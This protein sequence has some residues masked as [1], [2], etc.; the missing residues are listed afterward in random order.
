MIESREQRR[1]STLLHR[2]KV[3]IIASVLIVAILSVSLY[4]IY[5]YFNSVL[6]FRDANYGDEESKEQSEYYIVKIDGEFKMYYDKKG[7]KLLPTDIPMGTDD[8]LFVTDIGTT[9]EVNPETGEVDVRSIPAI[10]YD[11]GE[12]AE[13]IDHDYLTIFKGIDAKNIR[14]I[15]VHNALGDYTIC[16]LNSETLLPDDTSDFVLMNAPLVSVNQ[17][18]LSYL[19]YYAAHPLVYKRL[20]DPI[21]DSDGKYSEY[22]LAPETRTDA[23]G[24]EYKYTPSYYVITTTSDVE[25][26]IIIGDAL[27]DGSGY[28][29]Q[30]QDNDGKLRDS[31]YI[32]KPTDMTEV[33]GTTFEN[34]ILGPAKNYI[35]PYIVYPMSMND[36]YDVTDFS[37]KHRV[38][39]E[40]QEIVNFSF[41][42]LEDRTGTVHGIHPYVF[43]D[44]SFH[45]YHPHYDNIDLA[46]QGLMEPDISDIAIINPTDEQKAEYGLMKAVTGEDGKVSYVYDSK[47]TVSFRRTVKNEETGESFDLVQTVYISEKSEEGCY[48]TF[49]EMR[50]P[51][52]TEDSLFKGIKI[53]MI[54]EVSESSL[55]FV[56]WDTNDWVYPAFMQIG[57]DYLDNVDF[58]W[59]D[60]SANFKTENGEVNGT[61]VF[62]VTLTDSDKYSKDPLK[63]FGVLNFK[64]VGG[65][66][67]V[68]TPEQILVYSAADG[69]KLKPQTRH[70]EYNSIGDQVQV[71]DPDKFA[72]TAAGDKV[73][74]N[75]D[76]ITIL[77][78]NGSSETIMR[79]QTKLF[80]KMF[81]GIN[82]MKIVDAYHLT[83]EEEAALIADTDKHLLTIRTTD[84]EGTVKTYSFYSVTDRKAYITVDG[85]GG[86]Y[87]QTKSINKIANDLDKFFKGE[88]IDMDAI[89]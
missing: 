15:E 86:F 79:Y 67:W 77:H 61:A 8:E 47:Y 28:Y 49:T 66:T 17:D 82:S 44:D 52:A 84:N 32:L 2:R 64:D 85:I 83:T 22:G 33:N 9:V 16:R 69:S 10:Y 25:Y 63:T 58:I 71:I 45:S 88:S 12:D 34:T 38:D 72:V 59:N 37:I 7:E 40:L 39:G 18:Y 53:N 55:N 20:E 24:N 50:W 26:K 70:Y 73:Y 35:T 6:I 21:K 56:S 46:L 78:A 60:Y 41:V 4:F 30:Y 48:Y 80:Q 43:S 76:D 68:I 36:Y 3:A 27:L 5:D 42:D 75:K 89:D 62:S 19:T 1:R 87:V 81:A 54:C 51:T 74:I 29:I 11:E 31:V 65:N 14:H 13:Q 57:L 23:E